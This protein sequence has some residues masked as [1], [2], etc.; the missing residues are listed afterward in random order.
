MEIKPFRR[1]LFCSLF[2]ALKKINFTKEGSLV[3]KVVDKNSTV[4]ERSRHVE[5]NDRDRFLIVYFGKKLK[6]FSLRKSASKF[7]INEI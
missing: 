6:Y 7:C 3:T 2:L 4:L 5:Q 1:K